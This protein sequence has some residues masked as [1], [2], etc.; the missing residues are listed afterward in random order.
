MNALG[1]CVSIATNLKSGSPFEFL[2]IDDPIQSWDAEHEIQF[3]QVIRKLVERGKQVI[4][5]SHS[6]KW[7]EQVCHGCHA[8]N[9]WF[10]EIT[11][12]TKAGP[13]FRRSQEEKWTERLNEIDAIV[14]DP[15]AG[16]VRLQHA[17][18]EIRI[19][20]AELAS[21]LYLKKKKKLG[22]ALMISILQ[23]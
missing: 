16:G 5:L 4:L 23:R 9:G 12:Y 22:R 13:A 3:I 1:L 18:E 6:R 11:G 8:L 19:V 10:Y 20:I 14:K 17:E 2:I 7:I 21:L 15:T